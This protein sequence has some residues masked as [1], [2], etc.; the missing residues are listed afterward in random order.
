MSNPTYDRLVEIVRNL[1]D[2]PADRFTPG[3]TF[4][5]LDVDSL[6]MVDISIRIER[7]LGVTVHDSELRPTLTLRGTADLI[8]ARQNARR[9]ARQNGRPTG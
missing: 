7:H 3:T 8:D 1:H 6:T 9:D 5:E 4:A 2:A